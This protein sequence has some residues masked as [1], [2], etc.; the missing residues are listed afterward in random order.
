MRGTRAEICARIRR[1]QESEGVEF[2]DDEVKGML[3][4]GLDAGP[5]PEWEAR[6]VELAAKMIRERNQ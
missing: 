6:V 2:T 4:Q 5:G 1:I 3:C